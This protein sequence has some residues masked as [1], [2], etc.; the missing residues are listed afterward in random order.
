[1]TRSCHGS[2]FGLIIGSIFIAELETTLVLKLED[3][4]KKWRRFVNKKFVY[5]K[6]GSVECVPSFHKNI[7]FTCE[8]GQSNNLP[9]SSVL[10]IRDGENFNTIACG[11]DAHKDLYLHLDTF[12]SVIRKRETLKSLIGRA[13]T[14][15]VQLKLY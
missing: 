1:M 15:C 12:T 8:Q 14:W 2:L 11:K 4:I 9:F 6:N 13:Y 10:L 5:F 3:H 7:K